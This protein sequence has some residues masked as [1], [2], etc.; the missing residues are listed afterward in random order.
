M[1]N[2]K[3]YLKKL[4]YN[5]IDEEELYIKEKVKVKK[6]NKPK[7]KDA[8]PQKNGKHLSEDWD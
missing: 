6:I 4:V 2:E 5:E 3:A 1:K 7:K 8:K